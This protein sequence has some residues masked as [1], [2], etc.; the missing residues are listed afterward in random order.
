MIKRDL[1]AAIL[2]ESKEL[3]VVTI[4]GPRQ[5]GKTTLVKAL[6]PDYNYANLEN[7][8]LED[9]P[10]LQYNVLITNL[11]GNGNYVRY[12]CLYRQCD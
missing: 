5:S 12:L 10:N 3:P 11:R 8:S 6:F 2:R 9:S 7:F 1:S 4:T